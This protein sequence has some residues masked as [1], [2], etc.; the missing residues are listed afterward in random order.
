MKA[1]NLILM[2]LYM[3]PCF[4]VHAQQ[5]KTANNFVPSHTPLFSYGINPGY[6]SPAWTDQKLSDIAAGAGVHSSRLSLPAE[7]LELQGYKART[8]EFA[9]YTHTLKFNDLTVFIGSASSKNRDKQLYPG[10]TEPSKAFKGIYEPVWIKEKNNSFRINPENTLAAYIYMVYLNYGKYIAYWEVFNEPDFTNNWVVASKKDVF[11]SWWSKPPNPKDLPNLNCPIY[12][13][14]RMLRVTYEVIK[15]LNNKELVTT[16]GIGY[17]SFLHQ[18]LNVTD[19]PDQGK[20]SAKYPL[21]AGAYF[22]VLSFHDYPFYYLSYW[23]SLSGKKIYNR[24]S[25]AAAE[26]FI[27]KK[28]QY[29]QILKENGYD[30]KMYPLKYLI[31]TELNIPAKR[32][33]HAD[34]IGSDEAQKNFTIKSLVLAQKNKISQLY[35]FVLGRISDTDQSNDP[36]QLMGLY[37]NLKTCLPGKQVLTSQGAAF[38]TTSMLLYGYTYN[39]RLTDKM[40]LP[41]TASG[42]VFINKNNVVFVLWAKTSKDLSENNTVNY[43]TY[44]LKKNKAVYVH[45]WNYSATLKT[46][47]L[48]GN[49]IRLTPSPIF[50]TTK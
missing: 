22:D 27:T 29:E 1:K 6:Y 21:K 48:D 24:H 46:K 16:G 41:A 7:F 39:E 35:Y 4:A 12:S 14:V 50:I 2:S 31:C 28:N 30:G 11:D 44:V 8:K 38:K 23:D 36:Y 40:N 34:N 43:D 37:F 20:V 9:Y 25:D 47:I 33:L 5:L 15:K 49:L 3:L 26:E 32:Y 18:L 45:E 10:C 42:A 13:Y 17:P 19:N